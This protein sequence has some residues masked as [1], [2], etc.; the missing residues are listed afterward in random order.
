MTGTNKT[1]LIVDDV[2][3][4]R[5]LLAAH[6]EHLDAETVQA[7]SESSMLSYLKSDKKR[8]DLILLDINLA[9]SS[10]IASVA[11]IRALPDGDKLKLCF[12]SGERDRNMVLAAMKVGAIDYIVKPIEPIILRKKLSQMLGLSGDSPVQ[13]AKVKVNMVAT[14]P[15]VPIK[16]D[17]QVLELSEE[18]VRLQSNLEFEKGSLL[19]LEVADINAIFGKPTPFE[20]KILSV[21]K[22]SN[23]FYF[24]CCFLGLHESMTS[25]IRKFVISLPKQQN[26]N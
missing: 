11:K 23:S 14:F 25:K 3:E 9:E 19:Q 20:L 22:S 21:S 6:V 10:G 13:L 5:E 8:P 2:K 15:Q 18:G 1:V 4:M 16:A 17:A 7:G 24:E 12:I 26:V